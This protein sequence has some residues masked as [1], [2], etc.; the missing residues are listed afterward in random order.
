MALGTEW[1][2]RGT[3]A[4]VFFLLGG[5]MWQKSEAKVTRLTAKFFLFWGLFFTALNVVFAAL[6]AGLLPGFLTPAGI[7]GAHIFAFVSAAYLWRTISVFFYATYERYWTVLAGWG[8]VVAILGIGASLRLVP[9]LAFRS[10]IMGAF[11]LAGIAI[12][13]MG[14][15]SAMLVDGAERHKL[16]LMSTG[17]WIGLI[18]S[19][20][21]NNLE[22]GLL[23]EMGF[24]IIWMGLFT[25]AIWWDR[26]KQIPW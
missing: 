7:G 14:Y 19:N 18:L 26:A 6:D 24:N 13:G 1:M 23:Y 25:L 12:A 20:I 10:A 21:A 15:R 8:G 11:I 2:I 22:L 3:L 4:V 17:A 5:L 9:P 16:L